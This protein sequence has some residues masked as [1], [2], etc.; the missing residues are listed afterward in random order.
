MNTQIITYKYTYKTQIV[1]IAEKLLLFNINCCY[2][3]PIDYI[4][5][6]IIKQC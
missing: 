5:T 3:Q 2:L 4:N 6:Q 1:G